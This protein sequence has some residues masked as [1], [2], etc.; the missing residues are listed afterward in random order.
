M[1]QCA[2]VRKD[3]GET[4]VKIGRRFRQEWYLVPILFN[5]YSK[6]PTKEACEGFGE[7][8]RGGPVIR[9]VKYSGDLVLL[10]EEETMLQGVIPRLIEV[11]M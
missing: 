10:G 6:Y 11:G 9:T 7:I 4:S 8:E 1:D 2:E 3:R 5:L